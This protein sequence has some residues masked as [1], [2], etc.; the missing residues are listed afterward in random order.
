MVGLY[1][2]QSFLVARRTR[3]IGIRMALGAR[4]SSVVAGVVRGSLLIGGLGTLLGVAAAF[5]AAGLVR[6]FLFGVPP[7][8]PAV[9]AVVPFLLLLACA[10]ASVIPAARASKVSPIEA[11]SHE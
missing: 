7:H 6:G 3:E 5:A 2:V 1:G 10:L 8:D 9:F 11:L 4:V